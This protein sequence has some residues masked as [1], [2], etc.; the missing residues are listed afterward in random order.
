MKKLLTLTALAYALGES[1]MS[2]NYG[3]SKGTWR[4][5]RK[6]EKPIEPKYSLPKEQPKG[7]Q[8]FEGEIEGIKVSFY[9]GSEKAKQK[10]L[11]KITHEIMEY[12]LSRKSA[13]ITG[14]K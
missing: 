10:K 8:I 11:I 3:M 1:S 6:K 13:F 12:K 9:Y 7:T 14:T 5:E 4:Y 2:Y